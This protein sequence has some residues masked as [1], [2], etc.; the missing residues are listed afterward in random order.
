M[1]L[2]FKPNGPITFLGCG[3]LDSIIK[4]LLNALKPFIGPRMMYGLGDKKLFWIL[5]LSSPHAA[6]YVEEDGNNSLYLYV[7]ARDGE[8]LPTTY[9]TINY[10][11]IWIELLE[12]LYRPH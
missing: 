8:P 9:L 11:I 4:R 10:R 7:L 1:Y 2:D 12:K 3:S 5:S 6:I